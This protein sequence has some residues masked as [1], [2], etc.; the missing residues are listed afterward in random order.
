MR[1]TLERMCRKENPWALLIEG[2][3]FTIV[4]ENSMN[5]PQK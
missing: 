4:M 1:G 5:I 3:T 2:E